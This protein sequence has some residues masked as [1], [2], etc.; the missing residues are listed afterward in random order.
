MF[1]DRIDY[2]R[3]P[4]LSKKM[5]SIFT[6]GQ[7]TSTTAYLNWRFSSF[8]DIG[9]QFW[10]MAEGYFET[11]NLLLNVCLEDNKDKKADIY[12][13]PILFDIVHGTELAL[14]A[15]NDY[16]YLIL[17][18]ESKIE[19]NHNIKQL[20]DVSVKLL[21]KL[22]SNDSSEEIKDALVA[23]NLVKKFIDNIYDKTDDMAF[24]R[25][26]I[27][28]KDKE[29]F[30]ACSETN[31]TVDLMLLKE[32]LSYVATMLDFIMD[33]MMRYWDFVCDMKQE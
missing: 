30:Y 32:Q 11:A 10:Q 28:N 8:F 7:T 26:P 24:A 6:N 13:F 25:Y 3:I 17:D 21:N 33:L 19:G 4:E 22:K 12:I 14:K 16:L 27:T 5:K 1:F 15:I 20:S 9:T 31:V 29:M 18:D 23:I 2:D